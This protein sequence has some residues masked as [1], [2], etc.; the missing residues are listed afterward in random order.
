LDIPGL[1]FDDPTCVVTDDNQMF[2]AGDHNDDDRDSDSD[3][4]EDDEVD[5]HD[6]P[7]KNYFLLYDSY[8]HKWVRRAP[9]LCSQG[10]DFTLAHLAGKI[11]C[12]EEACITDGDRTDTVACYDILAD[13]WECIGV[14][15]A[16]LLDRHSCDLKSVGYKQFIYVLGRHPESN[17]HI[18]LLQFDP[19]HLVWTTLSRTTGFTCNAG[20]CVASGE[21]YLI[22]AKVYDSGIK[23]TSVDIYSIEH[24]H[25]RPGPPLPVS[26]I[27]VHGATVLDGS[28]YVCGTLPLEEHVVV[29]RLQLSQPPST[30]SCIESDLASHLRDFTCVGARINVRKLTQIFRP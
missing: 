1:V 21:I 11:Y 6:V 7:A 20:V 2:V 10:N 8:H 29:Y 18:A 17:I 5:D 13:Q 25:W 14:M 15:P 24:D 23:K 9:V 22:G 16:T 27:Y 30:W 26:Y 3:V 19:R 4:N 28:L 12:F